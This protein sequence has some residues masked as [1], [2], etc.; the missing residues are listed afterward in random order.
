MV[1]D[2]L[3]YNGSN[4]ASVFNLRSSIVGRYLEVPSP[5]MIMAIEATKYHALI[6]KVICI[7]SSLTFACLQFFMI[8]PFLITIII[9]NLLLLGTKC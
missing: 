1:H 8:T 9:K 3:V 4:K 2:F 6:T 5:W 7:N